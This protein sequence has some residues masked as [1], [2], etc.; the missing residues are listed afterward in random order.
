MSHPLK[1]AVRTGLWT[2]VCTLLLSFSL[3]LLWSRL[4]TGEGQALSIFVKCAVVSFGLS[5]INVFFRGKWKALVFS[6][7]LVGE[8]ALAFFGR[9]QLFAIIQALKA[10]TLHVLLNTPFSSVYDSSLRTAIVLLMTLIVFTGVFD[11][12]SVTGL[13]LYANLAFFCFV[14]R[15]YDV[16]PARPFPMEDGIRMLLPGICGCMMILSARGG[17]KLSA[18]P[19]SVLLT[20]AAFFLLPSNVPQNQGLKNAAQ[21]ITDYGSAVIP[22]AASGDRDSFSITAAGYQPMEDRLGGSAKPGGDQVMRVTGEKNAV[23]HLR[24]KSYNIYTGLAWRDTLSGNG[25]L[26]NGFLKDNNKALQFPS[27]DRDLGEEH[28]LRVT[29]LKDDTSTVYAPLR[30]SAWKG[31]SD[32]MVLYYDLSGELYLTRN[33]EAGDSYEVTWYPEEQLISF[34]DDEVWE[35][36]TEHYLTVPQHIQQE[37][38]DICAA[39]TA[40][41]SEPLDKA[42]A[43]RSWLRKSCRYSLTVEDPPENVDFISYF[44]LGSR[45]GYC[46]YFASA[47]TILCRMAGIPARYVTGYLAVTDSDGSAVVTQKNG[48]AWTEIYLKN[49]GWIT[50]DATPPE[51]TGAA[52]ERN[53]K[54]TPTP[55]PSRMPEDGATPPP[56]TEDGKAAEYSASPSPTARNV[57]SASPIPTDT[58]NPENRTTASPEQKK[59]NQKEPDRGMIL[60]TAFILLIAAVCGWI[61]YRIISRE[62]DRMSAASPEKSWEIY[63][64]AV[65]RLLEIRHLQKRKTETWNEYGRRLSDIPG[66]ENFRDACEELS[67]RIYG[68]DIQ[69]DAAMA[70][71]LYHNLKER[72]RKTTRIRFRIDRTIKS[73]RRCFMI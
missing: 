5:A 11:D 40:R 71:A 16:I 53:P 20:A 2:A 44:I 22:I 26:F 61:G 23:I 60:L 7:L 34:P 37:I 70:K 41:L 68:R 28:T 45:E 10:E 50:M 72:T 4:L 56:D 48:H 43:L 33:L 51:V 46:T 9:G 30:I 64:A 8:A 19:L 55:V 59:E 66:L 12:A 42:E 49:I 54:P 58:A 69:T 35:Y 1:N 13:S 38:R 32:R 25:A 67:G 18:I 65:L 31:L 52:D 47:M 57:P 63:Y 36:V 73:K 39:A 15:Q 3:S 21:S 27:A 24:A 62:P 29:M 17:K 14:L 6:V